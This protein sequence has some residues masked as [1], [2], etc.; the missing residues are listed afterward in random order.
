VRE[1]FHARRL[2]KVL[3]NNVKDPIEVFEMTREGRSDWPGW[4]DEYERALTHFESVLP[5]GEGGPLKEAGISEF[6]AAGR[7]LAEWR[8]A[9]H[10]DLPAL[11]LL[12]RTVTA[13][14]NGPPPGHPVWKFE[15]K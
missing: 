14:V 1:Q 13:M 3:L 4:R 8:F 2:G 9:H 6:A 5:D 7:V 15:E 12:S 10:D 11:V